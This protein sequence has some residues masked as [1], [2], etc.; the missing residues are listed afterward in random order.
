MGQ[1]LSMPPSGYGTSRVPGLLPVASWCQP[2]RSTY[3]PSLRSKGRGGS[4]MPL[5]NVEGS[6]ALPEVDAGWEA[7]A[8]TPHLDHGPPYLF[9]D[10]APTRRSNAVIRRHQGNVTS[11]TKQVPGLDAMSGPRYSRTETSKNPSYWPPPHRGPTGNCSQRA[12]RLS[13]RASIARHD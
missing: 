1:D 6:R 10:V 12:F 13:S 9:R 8:S 2:R 11:T 3:E 4:P 5:L 7:A